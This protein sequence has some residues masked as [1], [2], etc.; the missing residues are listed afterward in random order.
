M[1]FFI[2]GAIG[3]GKTA[4]L[5][6]LA[7]QLPDFAV[8][9]FADLGG[10]ENP[11]ARWRHETTELWLRTYVEK[12]QS[13]GRHVVISGEAVLREILCSPSIEQ[14]DAFH[15]CLLDCD[16]VT[17]VD[18]LRTWNLRTKHTD[19]L[20]SSLPSCAC[21]GSEWCPEV[22]PTSE[23]SIVENRLFTAKAAWIP[24]PAA[25]GRNDG[26]ARASVTR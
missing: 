26:S 10:P 18:R 23:P 8:H 15:L 25:L 19:P 1:L 11:D 17:R 6:A 4:C 7:R 9:D 20:L 21:S 14:V 3:V 13:Q 16:D 5:P 22:I 12:H 24:A 2:T